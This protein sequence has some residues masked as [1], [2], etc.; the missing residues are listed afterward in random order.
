MRLISLLLALAILGYVI[1]I[2]LDSSSVSSL[3]EEGNRTHPQQ[4][5][6][7]AEQ[8]T[9]QLN[10]VLQGNQQRLNDAEK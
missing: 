10:Q 8:V 9:E 6:E 5:I 4:T 3:E 2:Y 1:K 7:R